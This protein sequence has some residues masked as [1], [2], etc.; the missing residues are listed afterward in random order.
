MTFSGEEMSL[1]V[2]ESGVFLESGWNIK[3]LYFKVAMYRVMYIFCV[4][5]F[6]HH[7]INLYLIVIL[8]LI[9]K[10]RFI[11]FF[12]QNISAKKK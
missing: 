2:P 3:P 7:Y 4:V 5:L 1:D 6:R 8:W 11:Y 12:T 10:F 9:I